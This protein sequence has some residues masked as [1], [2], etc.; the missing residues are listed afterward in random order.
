MTPSLLHPDR[1]FVV[2]ADGSV[3]GDLDLPRF[4]ISLVTTAPTDGGQD[5][6]PSGDITPFLEYSGTGDT[7]T[8]WPHRPVGI[9]IGIDGRLFVT[10]DD[11]DIVIAIG[12]NG[13]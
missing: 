5:G 8:G 12:H 11:S 3:D 9:E 4:S 6:M 1:T 10:S 2:T 7:G 13:A